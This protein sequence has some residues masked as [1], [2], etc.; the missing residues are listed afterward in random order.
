MF[1]NARIRCPHLGQR[2]PR[3]EEIVALAW[4]R[5]LLRELGTFG[6]PARLHHAGQAVDHYVQKAAAGKSQQHERRDERDG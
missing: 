3:D 4:R 2:G 1:S 5:L 6:P